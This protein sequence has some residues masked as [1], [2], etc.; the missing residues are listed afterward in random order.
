MGVKVMFVCMGNICRSPAAEA[1]FRKICEQQ[2]L[3]DQIDMISCGTHDYHIGEPADE[4][5]RMAASRRGLDISAHRARRIGENDLELFDYVLVM[6]RANLEMVKN[7]FGSCKNVHLL[8]EF[9]KQ[10]DG[11][12]VPDPYYGGEA[13]FERVLD[14]AEEASV[15]LLE[16][17]R[18]DLGIETAR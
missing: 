12:E 10:P 5:M 11:P 9:A 14:M 17:I 2:G 8:M 15:G 18:R 13:G 16:V 6:D 1:V 4:R 7:Y 3:L